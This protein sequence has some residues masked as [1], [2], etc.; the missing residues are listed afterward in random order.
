MKRARVLIVDDDRPS[1][2]IYQRLLAA[3]GHDSE[4]VEN[5]E[6]AATRLSEGVFDLVLLDHVLPGATG[7][8]SLGRLRKLTRAPIYLTSGYTGEETRTDA[9]LLGAAGF[10]PKPLEFAAVDALI[11]ALPERAP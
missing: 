4:A 2:E 5:A 11:A 3:R 7:M 6:D 1:C 10:L 8:Q 9:E